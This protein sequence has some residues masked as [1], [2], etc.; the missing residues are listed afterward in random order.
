[1]RCRCKLH[2]CLARSG[3]SNSASAPIGRRILASAIRSSAELGV[4]EDVM[5]QAFATLRPGVTHI[6]NLLGWI[7][8]GLQ[9]TFMD[10]LPDTVDEKLESGFQAILE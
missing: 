9:E 2:A 5:G 1:M 10:M 3:S 8:A 7:S 6:A 4:N